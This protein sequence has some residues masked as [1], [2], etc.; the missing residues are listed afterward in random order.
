MEILKVHKGSVCTTEDIVVRGIL[1]GALEVCPS[2]HADI[3]GTVVGDI[4]IQENA[5]A[6]ID[7]IVH[8]KVINNGGTIN[9]N[10]MVD[11]IVFTTKGETTISSDARVKGHTTWNK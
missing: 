6:N 10:G 1:S 8:G 9:I 4:T 11:G 2:H 3:Y 5:S 7:G